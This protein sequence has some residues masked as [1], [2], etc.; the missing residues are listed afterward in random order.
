[1]PFQP[2]VD[3]AQIV[4]EGRVD[5][6]MTIND[7]YF[8]ISGGGITPVNLAALVGSVRSWW[9]GELIPQL[10]D[11]WTATRVIGV[12]L[13]TATGPRAELATVAT[14]GISG[15]AN[16]N[17]VAACVSIRTAQRGRSARGRNYV[18]A[19]PGSMV[20]LNTMD[21]EW[22]GLVIG[23]YTSLV[24][25][26]TFVAGWEQVVVSRF[27]AGVARAAGL[28]IPVTGVTFTS[29]SVRSMRS[30]EVGHGA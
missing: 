12:D 8:M 14:G 23:A 29:N 10:S 17:N 1:M 11:D 21:D 28:A 4:L 25:P 13:T 22:M 5:G 18:P 15:E 9:T 3:V 2:V 26:G 27:E 30:R 19:V 24:G 6:Q 16:P 20:V 7:L